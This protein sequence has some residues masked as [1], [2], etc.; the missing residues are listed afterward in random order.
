[1]KKIIFSLFAGLCLYAG[2]LKAQWTQKASLSTARDGAVSWTIGNK[3]YVVGGNGRSDLRE[4]DP[5]TNHWTAKAVIPQG[6]T[7]FAMGFV[8]NGKGYLCGG[9]NASGAYYGS[10]LEYDPATNLW[11]AKASL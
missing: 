8:I 9:V 5:T 7:S 1:M 6:V 3:F 4:Y 11:T 10:L 2:S